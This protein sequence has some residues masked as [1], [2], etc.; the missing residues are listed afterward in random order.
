MPAFI[1]QVDMQR[2][3]AEICSRTARLDSFFFFHPI[4]RLAA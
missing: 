1:V 2:G 4:E 3:S